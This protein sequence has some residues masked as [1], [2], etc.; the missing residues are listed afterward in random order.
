MKSSKI[1]HLA[2]IDRDTFLELL[3][4]FP[5]D[6]VIKKFD[7]ISYYIKIVCKII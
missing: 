7:V 3:E 6:K 1:T 5:K 2:Y 4:K